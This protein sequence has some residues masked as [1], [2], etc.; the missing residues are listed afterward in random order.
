VVSRLRT[1]GALGLLG[2]A[3]PANLALT[4]LA[5]ARGLA[6]PPAPPAVADQPRTVLLSGGKMTKAL[7]LARAFH[8]A[9]HRVV[10]VESAKY[11]LTGHRFSRA[12]AAFHCVPE[13]GDPGYAAALL[14]VVEREGVDV[15][16]PVCSPASSIHDA[17]A[18]ALLAPYCE[19]L[20]LDEDELHRV[21]DKEEFARLAGSMG[22]R[23]PESHRITDPQQVADFD[24]AARDHRFILKHLA[25]DPVNRLD[26]TQL[27]LATPEETEAFARSK[28]ISAEDP[29]VLQEMVVGRELCTHGTMRKGR[30]QVWACCES[31]AFQVNY[32][33]LEHPAVEAWVTR[34]AEQLGATGQL[35]FDFIEAADGTVTA[36]ECNPRTHSAITMFYDHP[37]LAAAYLEDD[38][39]TVRP[40][41]TSRPT[42][43][44]YHELWRVLTAPRDLRTRLRVLARG[45]DAIFDWDDPLPFLLVHHLQVPSLLLE[46][47]WRGGAFLRVDFNIGKL[48][49]A[50][51]D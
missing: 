43:W 20:H 16:V 8:A 37:G 29:W 30:V 19:V 36:I 14:D 2:L 1:L 35:S 34:F 9:G 3:L 40:T 6:R 32:A 49:E 39:G 10:L 5:L 50:G 48:V 22:L 42:Y 23:V 41:A 47:L 33:M 24:F 27:P 51:G 21:D 38:V 15:W 46:C 26:L 17:R 45:T 13:A 25:Y 44:T 18:K 12:V 4:T 7:A 31:S 28:Q 11:R